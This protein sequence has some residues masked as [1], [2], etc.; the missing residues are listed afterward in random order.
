[1]AFR[2]QCNAVPKQ[3]IVAS[4]DYTKLCRALAFYFRDAARPPCCSSKT[5]SLCCLVSCPCISQ[6]IKC[7][8]ISASSRSAKLNQHQ[9]RHQAQLLLLPPHPKIPWAAPSTCSTRSSS[10]LARSSSTSSPPHKLSL[11]LLLSNA[12]NRPQLLLL[13][14]PSLR[15]TPSSATA[16][17]LI[18]SCSAW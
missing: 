11:L 8:Y 18:A 14:P 2:S 1:M 7:K 13:T 17:P 5:R 16:R 15:C 4:F 10:P 6:H 3:T 9:P 12:G